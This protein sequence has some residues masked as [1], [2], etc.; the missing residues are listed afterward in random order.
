MKEEEIV[1]KC[2]AGQVRKK[3][4]ESKCKGER[5]WERANVREKEEE[6]KR[7]RE[8]GREQM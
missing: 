4:G 6:S 7:E 1:G 2:E 3:V 5:E 8:R